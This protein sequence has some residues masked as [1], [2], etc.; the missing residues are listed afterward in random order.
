MVYEIIPIYPHISEVDSRSTGIFLFPFSG[1]MGP[2]YIY[3]LICPTS[4]G[5]KTRFIP[6][7]GPFLK[8]GLSQGEV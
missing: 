4:L 5:Q 2:R 8:V 7:Q 3:R 1:S 6:Y